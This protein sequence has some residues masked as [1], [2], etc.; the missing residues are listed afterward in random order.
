MF[1][2]NG[3]AGSAITPESFNEVAVLGRHY[4]RYGVRIIGTAQRPTQIHNNLLTLANET[5]VFCTED[6]E[7]LKKKL[8]TKEN[9]DAALDLPKREFFCCR[10]GRP[11]ERLKLL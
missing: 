10:A 3:K 6:L 4:G 11:P 8:R 7:R 1:C 2:A 9:M 5:N